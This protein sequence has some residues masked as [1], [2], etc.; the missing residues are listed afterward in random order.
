M[1]RHLFLD[2]VCALF[3]GVTVLLLHSMNKYAIV[4]FLSYERPRCPWRNR[5]EDSKRVRTVPA[6][7]SIALL[8]CVIWSIEC[9]PQKLSETKLFFFLFSV[10]VCLRAWECNDIKKKKKLQC[11][12]NLRR[13]HAQVLQIQ[14]QKHSGATK[15]PPIDWSCGSQRNAGKTHKNV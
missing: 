2:C 14:T 1:K 9:H 4:C 3:W 5:E 12:P 11:Q 8:L 10:C 6:H 15:S 7:S 13:T